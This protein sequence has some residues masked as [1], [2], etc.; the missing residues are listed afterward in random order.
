MVA[1]ITIPKTIGRALSYN[2]QKVKQGV[3]TCIYA[4]NF[5]KTADELNFYQKLNRFEG[6]IDLNT[7]AKTNAVHISLNFPIDER[8]SHE[9][10]T[11]IASVYMD[12]IG[13]GNQPYLA[14]EHHDAG[15]PHIH[16][17]TTNIQENGQ[18][19][20]LHN[21]GRNQ[22]AIARKKIE[23]MFN[24]TRAQGRSQIEVNETIPLNTTKLNYGKAPTKQGIANVLN[25]VLTNYKYSSLSELNAILKQYNICADRGKENGTIYKKRG[26]VYRALDQ[27]ENKIGV[28]IKACSLYNKPTLEYLEKRFVE[29]EI[30]KPKFIKNLKTSIDWIMVNPPTNL[31]A[32]KDALGKEKISLVIRQNDNGII[33]GLTYVD[34]NT[35]CVFNGSDMGKEYS[36]NAILAKC[37]IVQTF[38]SP[39]NSTQ[40]ISPTNSIE[41]NIGHDQIKKQISTQLIDDIT[42]PSEE[43]QYT[44]IELKKRRKKK[45]KYTI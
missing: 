38:T 9:K 44:P 2:E 27:N 36:A 21:I 16:I 30:L 32:F 13:F 25:N 10:L 18:R 12:E 20:S 31:Q 6:L 28:P 26:L 39:K 5:L 40:T 45:R 35:K 14:Y 24:L 17:V 41:Q 43:L 8:I 3:A 19:I 23:Q 33:Y 4:H 22:S 15:H 11:Q 7:R 37:G 1:K 34:H 42:S 29:N